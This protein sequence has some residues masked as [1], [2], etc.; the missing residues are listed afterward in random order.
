MLRK[1]TKPI[2][3]TIKET[4]EGYRKPEFKM[5]RNAEMKL[6]DAREKS[7][8][9]TLKPLPTFSKNDKL[10]KQRDGDIVMVEE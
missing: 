8:V 4:K 10:M 9:Y 1:D 2:N 7:R 3:F 5:A 6:P